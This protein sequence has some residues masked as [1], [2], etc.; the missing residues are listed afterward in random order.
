[1]CI[2]WGA[3]IRRDCGAL[4]FDTS[5]FHDKSRRT[6]HAAVERRI[7]KISETHVR[8][9]YRRAHV[10]VRPVGRQVNVKRTTRIY[11][12]LGLQFRNKNAKRRV[13]A[14]LRDDRQEAVWPTNVWAMDFVHNQL[15]LS[16][17]PRILM[18]RIP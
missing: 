8:Y 13:K 4:R 7:K 16:N 3:S 11:D 6:A 15:A 14:K 18:S 2:N 17:K 12:K 1:M 10:L 5:T 9:D